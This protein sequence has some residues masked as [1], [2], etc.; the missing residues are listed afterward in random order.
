MTIHPNAHWGEF[1]SSWLLACTDDRELRRL[2]TG[3]EVPF[4]VRYGPNLA[5]FDIA[6]GQVS[7]AVSG[8]EPTFT[9]EAAPDDWDRFLAATPLPPYQS[10]FGMLMRVDGTAVSGSK[11]AF[12]QHA[13][14][15]RRVLE[16]ARETASGAT[17]YERASQD[18]STDA[19]QGSYLSLTVAS[20]RA[21]VYVE[22]TGS[23]YPIVLL[24]T[25][26]A[27]SRQYRHLMNDAT[28]SADHRLI[29]FD[30]PG[31]GKSALLGDVKPGDQS[32]TTDDY[33]ET[34]IALV[35][36]LKLERPVIV[37]ASMAGAICL[38]LAWRYPDEIGGVVACEASQ[39][40]E[41]RQVQWARHPLVNESLF[42]PEWVDGL[43]APMSPPK[44]REEIWWGYSQG[45]F[46]TFF[47][48]IL[49]YS[50]EWDARGRVSEIHTDRCPVVMLTGEYDYSCTPDMSRATAAAISG[51]T[52]EVMKGLGHFPH[53]EN[54]IRFAEYLL[55]AL[56]RIIKTAQREEHA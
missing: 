48:D 28:V 51:A 39:Y 16:L 42:V 40:V 32:L 15:V 3:A 38:E 26:G 35:R 49:F 21:S 34:V 56:N 41:G 37:G 52:F 29:A 2:S 14:V 25:A 12:A 46:G 5:V 6:D 20:H 24:H 11:L 36:A 54:P 31:H 10:W 27:D 8:T 43:M 44:H 9:L 45:G 55:P 18:V 23:G 7:A 19:R 50:G 22:Q 33:A 47:G 30:L 13:H 4:A 53:A 17:P 1:V